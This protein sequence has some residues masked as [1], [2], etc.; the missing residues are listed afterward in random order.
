[1]F[2]FRLLSIILTNLRKNSS[3]KKYKKVSLKKTLNKAKTS[4]QSLLED[5]EL[6]EIFEQNNV[7]EYVNK[8]F[9]EISTQTLDAVISK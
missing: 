7:N 6:N 5:H 9:T 4:T 2:I 3:R 8:E 1:M